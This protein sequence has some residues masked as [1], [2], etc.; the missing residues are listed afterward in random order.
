MNAPLPF[1]V[2]GTLRVGESNWERFLK[3]RSIHVATVHIHGYC[4]YSNG[5]FPYAVKSPRR[6]DSIVCNVVLAH[7]S[8]F[9]DMLNA[10]DS[11]EGYYGIGCDNHY[12]RLAVPYHTLRAPEAYGWLYVASDWTESLLQRRGLPVI[13][14]GDWLNR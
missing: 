13:T 14:S 10:V 5:S 9:A 11:L 3:N 2:Y 12:T 7:P 8:H 4:L 6:S 1:L